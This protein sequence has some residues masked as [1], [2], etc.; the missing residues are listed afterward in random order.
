MGLYKIAAILG[1]SICIAAIIGLVRFSKSSATYRPF[2]Y[3]VWLSCINHTLSLLTVFY[4]RSNSVNGNIFVLLES[5]LYVWFF[6]NLG[7]FKTGKFKA[8]HLVIVLVAVWL[9]DN[10][11]LHTLQTAN[12]G[13]RIISSF[14]LIFL[15]IEQLTRLITATKKNLFYNSAFIICCGL[16]IY[17]SFKAIIEVFF[18]TTIPSSLSLITG[19]YAILV[20]VNCFVNLLFAWAILWIPAKKQFIFYS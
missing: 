3:I 10:F 1:F 9:V 14:V 13:F 20:Y 12:A 8:L 6:N 16:L 4:F 11:L 5:V 2:F 17:F 19:I 15:S 18:L 7:H